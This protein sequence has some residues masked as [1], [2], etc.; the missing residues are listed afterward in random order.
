MRQ[1]EL[2][3]LG[4]AKL[5][6]AS[7]KTSIARPSLMQKATHP[8]SALLPGLRSISGR[9]DELEAVEATDCRQARR[10][11]RVTMHTSFGP[12]KG[13][14]STCQAWHATFCAAL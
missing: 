10:I 13:I 7:P 6:L 5:K 4:G 9:L 12:C 2:M 11:W 14:K 1:M 8:G 3:K